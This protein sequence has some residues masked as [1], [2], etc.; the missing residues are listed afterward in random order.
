MTEETKSN[1]G[2]GLGIAGFILGIVA[3]IISWIPCLGM[4]ALI[5]GIIAIILSAIA[6]TQANKANASKGLIIAAL[7][8]SILGT[9]I[10]GYQYYV[11]SRA[12]SEITNSDNWKDLNNSLNELN[13]V[14]NDNQDSDMDNDSDSDSDE[15]AV[16]SNDSKVDLNAIDFSKKLTP[17][18]YDNILNSYEATLNEYVGLSK[19]AEKGDLSVLGDYMKLA[20]DLTLYTTRI[21]MASPFMTKEQLDRFDE[22]NDKFNSVE[23]K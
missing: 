17:E 10:A 20:T 12:A 11:L 22:I 19:K 13:E 18:E 6:F 23:K 16:V 9:A 2:Q 15:D 14:Y 7:V 8:V 5:P 3:L 1:A 21:A 4:Y